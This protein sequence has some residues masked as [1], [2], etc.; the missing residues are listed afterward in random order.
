[1]LYRI[2]SKSKTKCSQMPFGNYSYHIYNPNDLKLMLYI[3]YRLVV[4][5]L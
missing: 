5:N 1:M 2:E 3:K 4:A